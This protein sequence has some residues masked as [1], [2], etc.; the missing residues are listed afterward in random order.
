[1]LLLRHVLLGLV[2]IGSILSHVQ[3]LCIRGSTMHI[4]LVGCSHLMGWILLE[5]PGQ[6]GFCH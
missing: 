5:M 4:S 1:M 3:D 2:I 6:V